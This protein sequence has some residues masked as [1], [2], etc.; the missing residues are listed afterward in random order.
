MAEIEFGGMTFKGGRM[1]AVFAALSTLGGA[2]WGG[3]EI[4]K[5]YMDMKEIIQNID[6]DE[7][8]AANTLQIQKLNDAID[9]T[10][11]IKDDLRQDIIKIDER[12]DYIDNVVR[13]LRTDL[14]NRADVSEDRIRATQTTIEATLQEIRDEMS[15]LQRDVTSS[16]R[17]VESTVRASE[18]D[19]RDTLRTTTL[20]LEADM[21]KLETDLKETIQEALDNP[22]TN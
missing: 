11:D 9:Y 7:I 21:D 8:N 14:T 6:I 16:I 2:A 18:K 13:E 1:V 22:L 17:E 5:D 3:F 15:E 4:Y 20:D 19:V 12:I 10:R